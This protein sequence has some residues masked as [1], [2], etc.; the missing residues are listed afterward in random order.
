[1]DNELTVKE[2]IYY[3][4]CIYEIEKKKIAIKCRVLS[5]LL[6]LPDVNQRIVHLSGGE[7]QRVS[8]A[9]A[10][11]HDPELVILDE[12]TVGLDVLLRDK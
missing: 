11:V 2:M 8:F 6:E 3:F 9:C 12:P 1:M 7:K 5:D 10:L 4:G